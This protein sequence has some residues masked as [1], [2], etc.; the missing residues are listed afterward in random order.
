MIRDART[1][2]LSLC[3]HVVPTEAVSIV[4]ADPDDDRILECAAAAKLVTRTRPSSRTSTASPR[5]RRRLIAGGS[6]DWLP[7]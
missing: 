4:K 6:Q 5:A 2:L 3:N 7:H 1:K